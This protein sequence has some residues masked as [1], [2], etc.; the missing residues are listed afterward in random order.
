[1][2]SMRGIKNRIRSVHSTQ[3]ITRAMN[4]VAASKLQRARGKLEGLQ[5]FVEETI[6]ITRDITALISDKSNP[7]VNARTV[8]NSLIIVISAD[9]GLCGGYNVNVA[10]AASALADE[11]AHENL[12]T[13]GTKARDYFRR[14]RKNIIRTYQGVSENPFYE[15]ASD[16]GLLAVDLYDSGEVDE[17]YLVYTKFNS[18]VNYQPEVLKLLPLQIEPDDKTDRGGFIDFEPDENAFLSY[19]VPKYISTAIYGAMVESA[20]CEQGA[21]MTSMDSAT[22]NSSDLI[23]R[24]TLQYNRARQD[25]I[26][27]E[28]T[29]IVSGANALT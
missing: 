7:Y 22:K 15:D 4:M 24:F 23:N 18:I 27:Q 16:I 6:R 9:R 20:A 1:M 21:R 14:R 26:T 12:I 25:A 10:K 5:P 28:L 2:S 3:Q 17:V 19:I 13:V 11:K 29:E 8:G